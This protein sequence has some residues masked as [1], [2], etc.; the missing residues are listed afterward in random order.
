MRKIPLTQG[1]EATVDDEDFEELSKIKWKV[2][3][4]QTKFYALQSGPRG[5]RLLMH[6]MLLK[7]PKGKVVDHINGDGLDNRRSNLRICTQS[8]NMQNSGL[9]KNSTSGFKGVCLDKRRGKWIARIRTE[10]KRIT[11]KQFDSPELAHKAY[12]ELSEKHHKEY[13]KNK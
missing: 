10:T 12:C 5:I 9:H 13:A 11:T 6:R 7:V 8:Q 1:K 3:K 2:L 4:T